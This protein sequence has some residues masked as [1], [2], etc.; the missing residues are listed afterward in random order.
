MH[1]LSNYR[2]FLYFEAV[3]F[4]LL[5]CAAIAIPQFFTIGLELLIGTLFL[6]GGIVQLIRLIQSADA[7]GFWSTLFGA[8][9]S[10]I[11]GGMLL[12]YPI[13][14]VLSLTY[15]LIAYFWVDGA[16]KVYYSM[17]LQSYQ[18]WGW[19][20]FSGLISFALG[21]LI[22]TGL[23]GTAL[24]AIGLLVGI[25]MLFFGATLFGFTLNLPKTN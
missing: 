1:T 15:L 5:G 6:V 16:T 12:F 22:F 21:I 11:L 14:G 18:R 17:Q 13:L 19:L 2:G 10:F 3:L 25:N 4:M 7:P 23:P 20:L 24:W 8:L 9:F